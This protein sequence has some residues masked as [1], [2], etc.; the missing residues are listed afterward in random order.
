[1][2]D[3]VGAVANESLRFLFSKGDFSLA[4][5]CKEA[6]IEPLGMTF[7]SLYGI[8]TLSKIFQPAIMFILQKI[9]NKDSCENS[10]NGPSNG[11]LNHRLQ[12]SLSLQRLWKF[13]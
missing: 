7:V 1:M 3:A 4:V 8:Y 12:T 5:S 13:G 9:F 2:S 10:S 11:K 6:V